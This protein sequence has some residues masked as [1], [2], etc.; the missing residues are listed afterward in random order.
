MEPTVREYLKSGDVIRCE[1]EGIGV[2]ENTIGWIVNASDEQSSEAYI[3]SMNQFKN[4]RFRVVKLLEKWM[5]KS[6]K[7]GL[8]IDKYGAILS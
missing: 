7:N 5:Q 4:T 6:F 3:L 1:I 2:L 8:T